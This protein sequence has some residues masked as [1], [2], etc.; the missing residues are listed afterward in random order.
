MAGPWERYAKKPWERFRQ[1][2]A[3]AARIAAARSGELQPSPQALE[4]AAAADQRAED[5]MTLAGRG[6]LAATQE[7]VQGVPFVGEWVDEAIGTVRPERA[8]ELRRISDAF[9]RERPGAALALGVAGGVAGTAPLALGAAG[10]GAANFVARGTSAISRAA[11]AG[12]VAAPAAAAEGAATFSGRQPERRG[13]AALEGAGIGAMMGAALGA[14]APTIG[15]GV[16]NLAR[17]IKKLD[18]S[19]IAS[20]LGIS[21]RAARSV[22]SYLANDD[23]D[24]AGRVFSRSDDAMLAEAGPGTR[25]LLDDAMATGG[26]ALR[27]G[28]EAVG[29]RARVAGEKFRTVLDETLGTAEGGVKGASRNISQTSAANRQ[30]LYDRAYAQPRPMTGDGAQAIDAALARVS[31]DV[32]QGAVRRANARMRDAGVRN[33]N[34]MASIADDGEVVFTQPLSVMQLDYIGR[35][36]GDIAADG[37]DAMT[38]RMSSE[39]AMASS[40]LRALRDAMKQAVPGYAAALRAGGDTARAQDAL[41]MG[42]RLLNPSTTVEDV[43][44][45]MSGASDDVRAAARKGLRENIEAVMDRARATI[46]DVEAGNVD[47]ETGVNAAGEAI[48]AVQSLMQPGNMKK[49]RFV[50]GTDAKRLTDEIEKV[51]DALVLRSAVARGSQTAIRTAG[52]EQINAE[53]A[54]GAVRRIAGEMGSPLD[55]GREL[56]RS[57]AGTDAASITDQQRAIYGEIAEAL[58]R[59]RGADAQR[60]L[61]VVRKA[62]EGQ[63]LKDAEADLIGRVLAANAGA[64]GY[65]TGTKAQRPQ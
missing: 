62:M 20:E 15:E 55:A 54:P 39:A 7:V 51:Y 24:A 65:Q 46:S 22:R 48:K 37:T 64:L 14:L 28:R 1:Q 8:A 19:T 27:T 57:L 5:R 13:P 63:P 43:R 59:I 61:A 18:V 41:A 42:R 17:R 38:G 26:G 23:L 31:P 4:R 33:Q 10:A 40:Q 45:A 58:T 36:L 49:L 29:P 3:T 60:A 47:F 50:M 6:G 34:I 35:A 52:R 12:A 30:R 53:S 2:S 56:T 16:A 9:E 32:M 21:P 25:Q 11:R 44:S